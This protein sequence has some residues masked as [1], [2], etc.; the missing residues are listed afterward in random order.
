MRRCWNSCVPMEQPQRHSAPAYSATKLRLHPAFDGGGSGGGSV[1]SRDVH[2]CP[3]RT[4]RW[5]TAISGS[6]DTQPSCRT[7]CAWRCA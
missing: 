7:E 1:R 2:A 4:Q 5:V 3:S 6:S